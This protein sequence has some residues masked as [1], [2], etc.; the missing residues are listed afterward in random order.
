MA[1]CW[2]DDKPTCGGGTDKVLEKIS[3]GARVQPFDKAELPWC[4]GNMYVIPDRS[5]AGSDPL[6]KINRRGKV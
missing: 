4:I 2:K 3:A 5:T 1:R 6:S